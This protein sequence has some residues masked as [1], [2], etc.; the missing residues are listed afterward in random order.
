MN[1]R[2]GVQVLHSME[3]EGLCGVVRESGK[4][5]VQLVTWLSFVA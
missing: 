3:E 5:L 4:G 1:F 2:T